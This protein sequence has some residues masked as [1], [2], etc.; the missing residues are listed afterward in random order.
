ME[1]DHILWYNTSF[2]QSISRLLL[3]KLSILVY[4]AAF[5]C[6]ELS[7]P[8][9]KLSLP[10]VGINTVKFLILVGTLSGDFCYFTE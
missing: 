8:G 1:L 6:G 4:M 7:L 3:M 2:Y 9:L 10:E 5:T